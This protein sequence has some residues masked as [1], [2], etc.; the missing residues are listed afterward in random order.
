VWKGVLTSTNG[1]ASDYYIIGDRLLGLA[2]NTKK[3]FSIHARRDMSLGAIPFPGVSWI[4]A[5]AFAGREDRDGVTFYRYQPE[6]ASGTG[7]S[8]DQPVFALVRVSDG[9]PA[10]IQMADRSYEFSPITSFSS[11]ITLPAPLAALS[12]P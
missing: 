4:T 12:G 1:S 5:A 7:A 8:S 11:P 2:A 9:Y 6:Q 10:L 3:P